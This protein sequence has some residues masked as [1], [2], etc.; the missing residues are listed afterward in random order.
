MAAVAAHGDGA[1][2][3]IVC[4]GRTYDRGASEIEAKTA[5]VW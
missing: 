3:G 2:S 1:S 5:K 4:T